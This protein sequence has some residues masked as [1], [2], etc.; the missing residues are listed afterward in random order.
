M[1]ATPSRCLSPAA[2]N[3]GGQGAGASRLIAAA[4]GRI[5]AFI[6]FYVVCA[7]AAGYFLVP[8]L[9]RLMGW[10]GAGQRMGVEM[11]VE[12]AAAI[13]A[14]AIMVRSI[15]R[16]SWGAVGMDRTAARWRPL[17]FGWC[18]GTAAIGFTCVAL[19]AAGLLHFVPA[20]TGAS[21]IG[22]AVRVTLVLVAAALAEEM[23]F[24]GY[25]LTVVK[26]SVGARAAVVLTSGVFGLVHLTNPDATAL[27]L[28]IVTLSG[29]LL[30]TVRLA[31][32][33][34][35]AAFMTHLAWNWVMAVP[36]HAPV[37]GLHF[38][39]PG[40]EA[41]T[42]GPSWLSGGAWGPEGGLVAALGMLGGLAYFYYT[43]RRRE[44]S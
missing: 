8:V 43:R 17:L 5:V 13:G 21:W 32:D 12:L 36:L 26:E 9:L 23:I 38:E 6:A 29:L 19:A 14:T 18:V 2:S 37:S 31:L 44:E 35:Y 28:A 40:Y 10:S 20:T 16:R 34:L 30:A 4:L 15:D 3:G 7:A 41:V 22:A 24:R 11:Y 39:S 27:S 25:L 33:S 42:T 1:A